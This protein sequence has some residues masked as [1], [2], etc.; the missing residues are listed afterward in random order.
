MTSFEFLEFEGVEIP[1]YIMV[2]IS[3]GLCR[4]R[5][6][7]FPCCGWNIWGRFAMADRPRT[8]FAPL[9][10]VTQGRQHSARPSPIHQF[11]S[12]NIS[13]CASSHVMDGWATPQSSMSTTTKRA[14]AASST[15]PDDWLTART[16]LWQLTFFLP[17]K[18]PKV[19]RGQKR[20]QRSGWPISGGRA[21]K[22]GFVILSGGSLPATRLPA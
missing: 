17:G 7:A 12:A 18:E 16:A 21:R 5:H 15:K 19:G 14:A 13:M 8:G 4:Q 2:C 1:L 11:I 9:V 20:S 3:P 22:W 10:D 6:H